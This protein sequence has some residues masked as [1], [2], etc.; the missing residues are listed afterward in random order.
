MSIIIVLVFGSFAFMGGHYLQ[1]NQK[2]FW[3]AVLLTYSLLT[4]VIFLTLVRDASLGIASTKIAE[5][6][7]YFALGGIISVLQHE[8]H[9]MVAE[10][11]SSLYKL[12]VVVMLLGSLAVFSIDDKLVKQNIAEMSLTKVQQNGK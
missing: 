7:I 2:Y 5:L 10:A 12:T 11:N 1:H 4:Q 6:T 3:A 8:Y 9:D